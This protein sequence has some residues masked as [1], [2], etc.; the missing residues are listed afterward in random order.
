MPDRPRAEA[1]VR[2]A[3]ARI[4]CGNREPHRIRDSRPSWAVPAVDPSKPFA[5]RLPSLVARV[6]VVDTVHLK[7]D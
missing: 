1:R 5:R 3:R 6:R 4:V 2:E 7:L